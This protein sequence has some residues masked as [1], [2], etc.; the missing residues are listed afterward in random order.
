[1]YSPVFAPRFKK[2]Y[3]K[4]SASGY[5]IEDVDEV[6]RSLASGSALPA[7]FRDHPLK[8]KWRTYRECHVRPDILLIYR[9][10]SGNLMLA[11]IG[12]HSDLFE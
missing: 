12:S 11:R 1:M 3:K 8:G 5:V 6:I 4:V 10:E 2:D 7:R 9:I